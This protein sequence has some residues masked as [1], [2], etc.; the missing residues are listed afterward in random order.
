MQMLCQTRF[1]VCDALQKGN[2]MDQR[3]EEAQRDITSREVDIDMCCLIERTEREMK[4]SEANT[5][6]RVIKQICLRL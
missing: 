2:T 4:L 6:R 3:E 1:H 5:A